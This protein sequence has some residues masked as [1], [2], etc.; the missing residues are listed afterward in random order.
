MTVGKANEKSDWKNLFRKM[1]S[2][3]P[4]LDKE[5]P[6]E[7]QPEGQKE[8]LGHGEDQEE[9]E[10][11]QEEKYLEEACQE[12]QREITVAIAEACQDYK[13]EIQAATR[14]LEIRTA[15]LELPNPSNYNSDPEITDD[16]NDNGNCKPSI[17]QFVQF[18]H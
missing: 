7:D 5:E 14:K 16:E 17:T 18:K 1:E 12:V 13:E 10:Q 8:E 6:P 3:Y 9:R 11:H 15:T 2:V 4:V